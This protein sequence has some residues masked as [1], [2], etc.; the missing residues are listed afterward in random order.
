MKNLVIFLYFVFL[1][2]LAFAQSLPSLPGLE[3][4]NIDENPNLI[5]EYV[6]V[7]EMEEP[8]SKA[9]VPEFDEAE[10]NKY[11]ADDEWQDAPPPP[12]VSEEFAAPELE[13]DQFRRNDF[14]DKK[15]NEFSQ[16]LQVDDN[17]ENVTIDKLL[18]E[19]DFE[20]EVSKDQFPATPSLGG[21]KAREPE[22][23]LAD[24]EFKT[25]DIEQK[26]EEVLNALFREDLVEETPE[27]IPLEEVAS[28]S[29]D[30]VD[31]LND[32]EKSTNKRVSHQPVTYSEDQLVEHLI[33]ASTVGN[34]SAVLGLLHSGRSAN[35]Q[36]KF[37]ETPL[38]AS[39]YNGHNSIT[40][41]LLAEGADPNIRDNKG[42]TAL[43]VA[44][45]KKNYFAVE[46]LIKHGAFVDPRNRSNDTPLL[47]A[48]LNNYL[49]IVDLLVRNGA[50]I[51]KSNDDGLTS[52]HVAA[53]NGNIEIVKYLLYVGA[54]ANMINRDGMKPYDLAYGRS[55]DVARLLAGYTGKEKYVSNELP[56]LIRQQN[57][58]NSQALTPNNYGQQFSLFPESYS[59]DPGYEQ[60]MRERQTAWWGAR[61]K[62][63]QSTMPVQDNN[64]YANNVAPT[65]APAPV[66]NTP[67][68]I[69][70]YE[71]NASIQPES[72]DYESISR[73]RAGKAKLS[74]VEVISNN[75][76][77]ANKPENVIQKNIN[78]M[79][80]SETP[81]SD[82]Y[83]ND[84]Y[85]GLRKPKSMKPAYT[86]QQQQKPPAST[87]A[88]APASPPKRTYT[89]T[90][91]VKPK[92]SAKPRATRSSTR[93]KRILK[94]S[95]MPMEKRISWDRNLE[96]WLR[97]SAKLSEFN[98]KEKRVWEKQRA[99]LQS[100]Y[101]DDFKDS[102]EKTKRKIAG[103]NNSSSNNRYGVKITPLK[104][105]TRNRMGTQ[106]SRKYLDN[107]YKTSYVTWERLYTP[108]R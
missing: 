1:F 12:A 40:E 108:S 83:A 19:D 54:N 71:N 23:S 94:Y 57:N 92:V 80:S 32:F 7:P 55:L 46:K 84:K 68:Q 42:N 76:G 74:N 75:Y 35:A 104:T 77:L 107:S 16:E 10:F 97:A 27:E 37:G 81:K 36:N 38:M 50:D 95:Q 99:I 88:K 34:K 82:T 60:Q 9:Q 44:A 11:N 43:H 53:F 58:F 24:R 90:A 47:I 39:I 63:Q 26:E 93:G 72:I 65:P 52:L 86:A 59:E 15:E 33:K 51:N 106:S 30:G 102:V 56:Q 66:S 64:V 28:Q 67:Q 62:A 6:E 25:D 101:Q 100:V 103:S 73:D 79:G 61:Q 78:F 13:I 70:S 17:F 45:S 14:E 87:M 49:D 98:Q 89:R 29:D 3:S 22:D 48:T 18:E 41:V 69:S 4:E 2:K 96:K 31:K 105:L 20:I 85:I 21:F 5:P 91:S 8:A